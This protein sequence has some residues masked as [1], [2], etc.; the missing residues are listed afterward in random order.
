MR[1]QNSWAGKALF[2]AIQGG[3]NAGLTMISDKISVELTGNDR[4]HPQKSNQE[5]E[6]ER[7]KKDQEEEEAE[8]RKKIE[9]DEG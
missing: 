9:E 1:R 4:D 2:G 7:R 8:R 6:E 3:F 5:L